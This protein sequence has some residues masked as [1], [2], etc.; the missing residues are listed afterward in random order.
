[1]ISRDAFLEVGGFDARLRGYEDDDLFLRLLLAG[2][3]GSFCQADVALWR[4]HAGQTSQS[5]VFIESARIF[6]EKW[7][8]HPWTRERDGAF[9]RSNLRARMLKNLQYHLRQDEV[10]DAEAVWDLY[11]MI[12]GWR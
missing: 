8:S 3:E 10:Y 5:M 6:F 9:A 12:E 2:Y 7:M 4:R 1:M 11:H